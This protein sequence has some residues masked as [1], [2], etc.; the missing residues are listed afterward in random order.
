MDLRERLMALINNAAIEVRN[1]GIDQ[2]RGQTAVVQAIEPGN[3]RQP[4]ELEY[5]LSGEPLE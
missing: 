3:K 5:N 1:A 2:W 4:D